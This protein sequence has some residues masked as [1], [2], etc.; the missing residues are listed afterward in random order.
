MTL[1]PK[2]RTL[3][4]GLVTLAC[5]L[6]ALEICTRLFANV[7]DGVIVRDRDS[8]IER[9]EIIGARYKRSLDILR[10]NAESNQMVPLQTNAE[11]FND[12]EWAL[13]KPAGVRRVAILG[14][15]FIAATQFPRNE[16]LTSRLQRQ[17]NNSNGH[18]CEVMNFAIAGAS[19]GQQLVLY[20]E[21][22]SKYD[23][24]LVILGFHTETDVWDNSDELSHIPIL[25]CRIGDNGQ[26]EEVRI[27]ASQQN[28]STFLNRHSHF[29]NW[30]KNVTNR[31]IKQVRRSIQPVQP[32]KTEHHVFNINPDPRYLRAWELTGKILEQIQVETSRDGARLLVVSIPG[33]KQVYHD[34]FKQ[35][36]ERGGEEVTLEA[37]FP[38]KRLAAICQ[39]SGIPYLSLFPAFRASAPGRDSQILSQR[40]FLKGT[41]HL[42]KKGHEL[43]ATAISSWIA[44]AKTL[45]I[46]APPKKR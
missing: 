24:D 33:S 3:I 12:D 2:I 9:D 1:K 43:A 8:V 38:D 19:T 39:R 31:F 30:Q 15:S 32:L 20:R 7:F 36:M 28:R 23:P 37:E 14:D 6:L 4:E 40:L 44:G 10:Y 5:I 42:N 46:P 29:Y 22:A 13:D 16:I 26:L 35:L 17:L 18:R 25:R 34:Q 41:G 11:G 21:L 45:E 27:P